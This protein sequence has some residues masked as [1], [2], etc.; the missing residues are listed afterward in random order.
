MPL[1]DDA[2]RQIEGAE[3]HNL[4][5]FMR[6]AGVHPDDL[7][8]RMERT[9]AE[10]AQAADEIEQ[11]ARDLRAS[12][13]ELHR[14]PTADLSVTEDELRYLIERIPPEETDRDEADTL[15]NKAIQALALESGPGGSFG[16]PE[17]A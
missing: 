10:L 14:E 5:D 3:V 17:A 8:E 2:R 6:K 1:D 7:R 12:V 11:Q 15:L 16:G 9:R 4:E 13:T